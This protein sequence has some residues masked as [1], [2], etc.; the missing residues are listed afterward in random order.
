MVFMPFLMQVFIIFS[1][2]SSLSDE[3]RE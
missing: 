2:F 1:G 3:K